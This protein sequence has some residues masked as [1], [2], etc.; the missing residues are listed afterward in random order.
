MHAI[1]S[2]YMYNTASLYSSFNVYMGLEVCSHC[3]EL[4][5]Y[6]TLIPV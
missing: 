6:D 1:S 3:L 2:N 4:A 5:K